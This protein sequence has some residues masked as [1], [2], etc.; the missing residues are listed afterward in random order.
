MKHV[1]ML[2]L[3]VVL[4]WSNCSAQDGNPT[5]K[6]LLGGVGGMQ[7]LWHAGTIETSDGMYDCCSFSE[8]NGV[9]VSMGFRGFISLGK[10]TMLRAGVLYEQ[11]NGEYE[12]VRLSYPIL[13]AGNTV[14][15]ANLDERLDVRLDGITAETQFVIFVLNPMLY[16]SAGPAMHLPSTKTYTHTESIASPHGVRYLDGSQSKVLLDD[17]ISGVSSFFSLRFGV[18]M[19][20]EL[21]PGLYANPDVQYSLALSDVR[22][23]GEWSVSGF[24]L[25]LGVYFAF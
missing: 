17:D 11:W 24:L 25:S 19:L 13:G 15:D 7:F 18:G 4:A 9:G 12:T 2:L 16:L 5:S 22:D 14:E 6:I 20:L 8:G 3:C 23:G 10:A 1:M 21:S